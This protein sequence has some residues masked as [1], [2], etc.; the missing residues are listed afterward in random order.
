MQKKAPNRTTDASCFVR[1][2]QEDRDLIEK[3][4]AKQLEDL[5]AAKM[6]VGAFMLSAAVEKAKEILGKK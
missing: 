3:A 6:G 2:P 5:P 4:I 1:M